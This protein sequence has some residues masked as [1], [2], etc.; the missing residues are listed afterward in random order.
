MKKAASIMYFLAAVAFNAVADETSSTAWWYTPD[1]GFKQ[2]TTVALTTAGGTDIGTFTFSADDAESSIYSTLKGAIDM[3]HEP[4]SAKNAYVLAVK[5]LAQSIRATAVNARQDEK[6]KTLGDTL[7]TFLFADTTQFKDGNDIVGVYKRDANSQETVNSVKIARRYIGSGTPVDSGGKGAVVVQNIQKGFFNANNLTL[8]ADG[9]GKSYAL[10]GYTNLS[11]NN[12]DGLDGADFWALSEANY[13]I[14]CSGGK[15]GTLGWAKWNGWNSECFSAG[16]DVTGGSNDKPLRLRGW[17]T[18]DNCD[19]DLQLL[20]TNRTETVNRQKHRFLTRHDDGGGKYSIHWLPF[21]DATIGGGGGAVLVDDRSVTTNRDSGAILLKGFEEAKDAPV[22]LAGAS[23]GQTDLQ[24]LLPLSLFNSGVFSADSSG[25]VILNAGGSFENNESKIL[26]ITQTGAGGSVSSQSVVS[27]TLADL[28]DSR[29]LADITQEGGGRLVGIKGWADATPAREHTLAETLESGTGGEPSSSPSVIVRESDGA[30][31]Y[32]AIGTLAQVGFDDKTITTNTAHGAAVAEVASIYGFSTANGNSGAGGCANDLV[33]LL[34]NKTN[35]AADNRARHTI[36]TRYN[37]AANGYELHWMP[38]GGTTVGDGTAVDDVSVEYKAYDQETEKTVRLKGFK[39]ANDAAA[40]D[41]KQ[42]KLACAD[43]GASLGWMLPIG[44]FNTGSFG[45]DSNG[46]IVLNSSVEQSGRT[47]LMTITQTGDSGGISSQTIAGKPLTS[48]VDGRTLDDVQISESVRKLGIKGWAN[49]S[50]AREHTLA[51]TLEAGAGSV[52]PSSPAVMVRESDGTLS[53]AAIG[54]LTAAAE[55]DDKTITTNV[56][57]GAAIAG[58]LSIFGW[59]AATNGHFLAKTATGVEWKQGLLTADEKSVAITNDTIALKGFADAKPASHDPPNMACR[60]DADGVESLEWKPLTDFFADTVFHVS[61]NGKILLNGTTEAGKVKVLTITGAGESDPDD[62]NVSSY[63]FDGRSVEPSAAHGI[64]LHGFAE[65]TPA[66]AGDNTF[67]DA[68][69][70][71]NTTIAGMSVPVRVPDG[72]NGFTVKYVPM[73]KVTGIPS[74]S[75]DGKTIELNETDPDNPFMQ[76]KGAA[77]EGVSHRDGETFAVD[78]SG[79]GYFAFIGTDYDDEEVY[80]PSLETTADGS[81]NRY[82]SLHGWN[83]EGRDPDAAYVLAQRDGALTYNRGDG[84]GG[85]EVSDSDRLQLKGIENARAG[86]LC[87]ATTTNGVVSGVGWMAGVEGRIPLL[88]TNAPP[89]TLE[90]GRSLDKDNEN[91][92]ATL[93][94][95]GFTTGGNCSVSLS[96]L[97]TD[98]DEASNR[99][100]HQIMTRFSNGSAPS[101]HWMSI[102]DVI[103]AEGVGKF[104]DASIGTNTVGELQIHG[105]ATAAENAVPFKNSNGAVEWAVSSSATNMFL[106]GAGIRLTDNGAGVVTISSEP[107]YGDTDGTVT[108]SVV[109]AVRYDETSHKFQKKTRTLT[110]KGVAGTES[111]W[112]DVFDAV[113]HASEHGLE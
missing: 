100:S 27:H 107:L 45:T 88:H 19:V 59:S 80:T 67:A 4:Q 49:A 69:T 106:A 90:V 87:Y 86:A 2:T 102:G 5:S 12:T 85:I 43:G 71:A 46:K 36:L 58:S 104:D 109:T 15:S 48:L 11:D 28:V 65:G 50:P 40:V 32:A 51:E 75:V 17:T 76:L 61:S 97:L 95:A 84:S 42:L 62:Q 21:S 64:Q 110:F 70:N 81:G 16:A 68:L 25:K 31:S 38:F 44:M 23:N 29:M 99:T 33:D 101:V 30:I 72:V 78:G 41:S 57:N 3:S 13:F 52:L 66:Y 55:A 98:P 1:E 77:G 105:F 89:T 9:E 56:D 47:E 74:A 96:K 7:E 108:L 113:S 10:Y 14:P 26:T 93:N 6:I 37:D 22:K 73:G 39:A 92:V 18:A 35:D 54:A 112:T 83:A 111:E 20:L 82:F 24:W 94:V 34:T 63:A 53:Y 8:Q 103:E 91:A 79:N 60:T